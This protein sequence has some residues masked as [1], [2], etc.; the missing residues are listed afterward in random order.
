VG[1]KRRGSLLARDRLGATDN[2]YPSVSSNDA[3]YGTSF[4]HD[5]DHDS[6]DA[7]CARAVVHYFGYGIARVS[8]E[9]IYP[10]A[11]VDVI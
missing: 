7:A 1:T 4:D 3:P 2:R 11:A 10:C 8:K 5:Y 6:D 9:D